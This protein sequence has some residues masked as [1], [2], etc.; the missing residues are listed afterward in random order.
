M[1]ALASQVGWGGVVHGELAERGTGFCRLTPLRVCGY[2][3]TLGSVYLEYHGV[4]F[5]VPVSSLKQ[6][7]PRMAA[8]WFCLL[9]VALLHAPLAGAA[10]LAYGVDCCVGGFCNVPEHHH[11]KQ[12]P[13][14]SQHSAPMDCGQDTSGMAS[15]SISCCKDPVR[16]AL[17]PGAFLLPSLSFAP[18]AAEVLRSVQLTSSVEISRFVKPISPPPRFV[19]AVL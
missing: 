16:P 15:C 13:A 11:H 1:Q 2:L 19:V 5:R 17:I 9:A 12:P 10:L 18:A 3:L 8:A 6:K 14:G 4:W 7:R